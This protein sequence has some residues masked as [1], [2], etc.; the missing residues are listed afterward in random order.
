MAAKKTSARKSA[1]KRRK[2]KVLYNML[3]KGARAEIAGL[4]KVARAT[5]TPV[6]TISE[7][8]RAEIEKLLQQ[9]AAGTVTREGLETGLKDLETGLREVDHRLKRMINHV[10]YFL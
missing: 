3:S 9:I 8:A 7:N 6:H 2:P 4:A 10:Y 5:R 1:G